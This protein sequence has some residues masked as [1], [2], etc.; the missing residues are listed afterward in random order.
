M[1]T[2]PPEV[3]QMLPG[4]R[5]SEMH[6]EIIAMVKR[7][8]W[9]ILDLFDSLPWLQGAADWTA[10]RAFLAALYGLP[11]TDREL[12][13][14]RACT[15]H[16]EAPTEPAKEC[17]TPTGRRARKSAVAA[18][19][20]IFEGGFRDYSA[21]L[22]PGERA[23]IPI[24]GK[25]MEEAQQ[26]AAYCK[27][28]LADPMLG[29]LLEEAPQAETIKLVTRV[30]IRIRPASIMSGRGKTIPLVLLDECAFFPTEGA[31]PDIEIVR[32]LRPGMATVP[33]AKLFGLSSPWGRKGLLYENHKQYHGAKNE[34]AAKRDKVLCWQAP[35]L[36][37]HD[38]PQLR[39]EIADAY[40]KDPIA[41]AAEYGAEFRE[42]VTSFVLERNIDGCTA[43][44][45]S[46][47]PP[48]TQNYF[49]FCDPSGGS[50]D[51]LA[52]AIAHWEKPAAAEV[53]RAMTGQ[54][55]PGKV[56]LDYLGEWRA[57]FD[58]EEVT[59]QA[60][61][62]L[63][64]Y[65][66]YRVMGDRYGGEWPAAGFRR[67]GIDYVL[68]EDHKS[69]IY[70]AFLPLLNSGQVELLDQPRLKA[71]L[72]DLDRRVARGGRESIDH[73]S[74]GHDDVA[75]VVAGACVEAYLRG[76][77]LRDARPRVE[78]PSD[79]MRA[80]I[81]RQLAAEAQRESLRASGVNVYRR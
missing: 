26:I 76:P 73:P 18:V 8:S 42:D 24:I 72:L 33:G 32:A 30:D 37:M 13:I 58:T 56:V 70:S 3:L 55:P 25:N 44:S 54:P 15:G 53:Y 59:T 61:S 69:A 78:E 4:V 27:A 21:Y 38:T 6:P 77:L 64:G 68:A 80:R 47:I 67:K 11:M 49:A 51:S 10:W 34:Q 81:N 50:S 22:A 66:L 7:G 79:L 74:G 31:V 48:G 2:A 35:T 14:Y 9:T 16:L 45:R 65:G 63:K 19:I 62:V 28:I 12:A 1:S 36:T 23:V 29:D 39:A 20:A 17:W 41:A 52:L 75:N 40:R 46:V 71:Q 60:A 57:P 43:P 5:F